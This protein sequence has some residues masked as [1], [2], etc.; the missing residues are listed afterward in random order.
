MGEDKEL[1]R[2]NGDDTVDAAGGSI[3]GGDK[4]QGG[5]TDKVPI[6]D[7]GGTPEGQG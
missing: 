1:I 6:E 3:R 4:G 5:G 2:R 7:W